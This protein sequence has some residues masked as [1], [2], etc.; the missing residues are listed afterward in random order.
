MNCNEQKWLVDSKI[1]CLKS[2]E[3]AIVSM[4]GFLEKINFTHAFMKDNCTIGWANIWKQFHMFSYEFF[5]SRNIFLPRCHYKL[6]RS[7]GVNW[8]YHLKL[9][10]HS[11]FYFG[12]CFYLHN[13]YKH[14][15]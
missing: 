12:P 15:H 1:K 3:I 11:F 4:L 5:Y 7:K 9:H 14:G 13:Q 6:E 2:F 10:V 8:G